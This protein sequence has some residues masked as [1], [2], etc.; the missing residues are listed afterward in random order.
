MILKELELIN[1]RNY[2]NLHLSFSNNVN[3]FYGNNAEGKTNVLESIYFLAITKS[4][5]TSM[6]K[7]LL[8][9]DK[10][11]S[12]IKGIVESKN[13]INKF[14]ILLNYKGKNVKINNQTIKKISNY[15]SKLNVIIFYP[16]DLELIK[17]NPSIRR[18]Y[19][20]IEIGQINNNYLTLL[21]EYNLLVKNRNEYIKNKLFKD[22]D[23][24][25]ISIIDEQ[26]SKK[27]ASI[28][29]IRNQFVNRI[30]ENSK[31]IYKNIFGKGELVI[32]YKTNI[33]IDNYNQENIEKILFNKL[34]N[35]IKRDNFLG[36]TYYGPHR[37]DITFFINNIEVKEQSSQ[38]QQRIIV[39]CMKLGEIEI[40]KETTKEYPILLLDDIFS[41]LDEN[42]KN[43]LL[44]YIKKD[45]QTFITTTEINNISASL[46]KKG[47]IYFVNN[48]KIIKK[49]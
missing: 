7:S 13:N 12:K 42:K 44:K 41:E 25:Y 14:E 6:D 1:F 29:V 40:I 49:Q 36:M 20:N 8:K 23:L 28:I 30:N 18:K 16:N 32:K 4:H 38:G 46:I 21:N 45:I 5:R 11:F 47:N 22:I 48:Q 35:N 31:K 2:D 17:G 39:I 33:E 10:Q 43:N 27:G 34:K 26:I 24:N 9:N 19:L 15:I 37:D 3:I